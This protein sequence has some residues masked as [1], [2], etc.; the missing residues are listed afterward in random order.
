MIDELQRLFVKLYEIDVAPESV[1][2]DEPLF[3]LKSRFNLDSMDT[4]RFIVLLHEEYGLDIGSADT[5]SFRTLHRIEQ[6]VQR[7]RKL[8]EER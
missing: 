8:T 2:P 5:E 4:L 3:G 1:D 7:D 6:T